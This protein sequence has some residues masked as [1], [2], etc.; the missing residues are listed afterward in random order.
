MRRFATFV[1]A[2]AV[3]LSGV[4]LMADKAKTPDDLDK[5]MK[6]VSTAQTALNKAVQ[7]KGFADARKQLKQ[8]DE[9]LEDA[10]N[11]WVI[12]KKDDAIAFGKAAREKV[13]ALDKL[14]AAPAPD[15][16]AVTTASRDVA[17]SCG[18]CHRIYRQADD[19]GNFVLKPGSVK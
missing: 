19:N 18:G 6:R 12:N 16:A 9:G 17:A 15:A 4:A 11:F 13:A 5:A 1:V 3:S 10:Q 8:M 7:A 2:L 14:L